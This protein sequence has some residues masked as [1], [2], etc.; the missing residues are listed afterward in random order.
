MLQKII[1]IIHLARDTQSIFLHYFSLIKCLK[2]LFQ[3]VNMFYKRTHLFDLN[4]FYSA[5]T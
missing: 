4:H 3:T 5:Q 1:I 2:F